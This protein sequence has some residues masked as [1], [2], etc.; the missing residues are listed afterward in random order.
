MRSVLR[1]RHAAATGL[2]I[3]ILSGVTLTAQETL[4]YSALAPGNSVSGP[5]T[6]HPFLNIQAL[7]IDPSGQQIVSVATVQVT[8]AVA[9]G[10]RVG[11]GAGK[12]RIVPAFA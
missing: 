12:K 5:G 6:V 8:L 1:S 4:N 10:Q 11:P 7:P 9:T 3:C 2:I